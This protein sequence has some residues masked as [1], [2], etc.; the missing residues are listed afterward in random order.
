MP[1]FSNI[2]PWDVSHEWVIISMS[3]QVVISSPI[4]SGTADFP[5][6][7]LCFLQDRKLPA[8]SSSYSS[9][10]LSDSLPPL[11]PPLFVSSEQAGCVR[12]WQGFWNEVKVNKT[13]RNTQ[14]HLWTHRMSAWNMKVII[15]QRKLQ[16][17]KL[18]VGFELCWCWDER[19]YRNS[20]H[21]KQQTL[22][23]ADMLGRQLLWQ[24][25]SL[26]PYWLHASWHMSASLYECTTVKLI[27]DAHGVTAKAF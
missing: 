15:F 8:P 25:V 14:T 9:P 19:A 13:H 1:V 10:F 22:W 12:V 11:F 7:W 27:S 17:P 6:L 4:S 2:C 24:A 5:F 23:M 3:S 21:T 18:K 16:T 20:E 26:G